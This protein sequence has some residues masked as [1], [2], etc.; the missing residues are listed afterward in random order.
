MPSGPLLARV[1][2]KPLRDVPQMAFPPY[3]R[4]ASTVCISTVGQKEMLMPSEGKK[5]AKEPPSNKS[6]KQQ[7]KSA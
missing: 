4:T 5:A 3:N 6:A 2:Q 7:R 1:V